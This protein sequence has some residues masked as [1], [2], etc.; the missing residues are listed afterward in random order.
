MFSESLQAGFALAATIARDRGAELARA[1][2]AARTQPLCALARELEQLSRAERRARIRELA[3]TEGKLAARQG[4]RSPRALALITS[5]AWTAAPS[6][7]S[8]AGF[9]PDAALL[10]LLSR[11]AR[12]PAG[13]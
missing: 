9:V 10:Q 7:S 11:I 4:R 12:R 2:V 13:G 6:L 1:G 8:R 5:R 3:R